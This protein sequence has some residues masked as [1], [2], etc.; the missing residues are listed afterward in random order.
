MTTDPSADI[1]P[2]AAASQPSQPPGKTGGYWTGVRERLCDDKVTLAC[3]GIIALVILAAAAAPLIAPA[4]PYATSMINRL[5]PVGF[6]G[7]LL[8]T[9]ELG[10]D[11]LSR[12]IHGGRLSLA[13]GILPVALAVLI[14]GFLGIIAGYG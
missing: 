5:R 7:H 4:D 10:R 2:G 11:M 9:D 6:A 8:G 3:L 12:L 13:M 1:V 14:G